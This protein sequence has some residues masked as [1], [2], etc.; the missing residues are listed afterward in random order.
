MSTTQY[1]TTFRINPATAAKAFTELIDEGVLYQRRG[2]GTFVAPGARQKLLHERRENY[3]RHVLGPAL[4]EAE[5]IGIPSAAI[6]EYVERAAPGNDDPESHV[7]ADL[8]KER[9]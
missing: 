9:T 4:E 2:L 1:A 7:A 6:T 3:F 8:S 5:R